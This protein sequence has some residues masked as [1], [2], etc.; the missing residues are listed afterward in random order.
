MFL[1]IRKLNFKRKSTLLLVGAGEMCQMAPFSVLSFVYGKHLLD[2]N[3]RRFIQFFLMFTD[4]TVTS[5]TVSINIIIIV[6]TIFADKS[7]LPIDNIIIMYFVL[8]P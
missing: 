8:L 2:S 6:C 5:V 4:N 3:K 1:E 7:A